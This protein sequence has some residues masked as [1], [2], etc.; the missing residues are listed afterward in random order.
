MNGFTACGAAGSRVPP[1]PAKRVNFRHGLVLG[2][3]ELT[4]ESAYLANRAESLARD[5]FGYGTVSGLR[6][7]REIRPSGAAIV[8][9]AG[10][11]LSPRGRPIRVAM[12]QALALN[13]WLDAHRNRI[14]FKLTPGGGS[15]P[16]DQLNL[17]VVLGYRQCATD[18]QPG[19]GE[20]CRTDEPPQIFTR[21][22]DDFCLE[23]RFDAPDQRERDAVRA[24]VSWIDLVEFVDGA[25]VTAT[26][27]EFLTALRAAAL[28][29][30]PPD[31]ALASPPDALRVHVDDAAAFL[32]A[33]LGVWATELKPLWLAPAPQ[34]DSVLLAEVD[35]PVRSAPNGRWIVDQPSRIALDEERRPY[36]VPLG[37]LQELGLML[38]PSGKVE[39]LRTH[40][41]FSVAAAGII[42]GDPTNKTHRRPLFNG[43][44]VTAVANGVVSIAFDGYQQP[45]P[46]GDFQ[47]LVKATSGLRAASP[48]PVVITIGGFDPKSI[49]LTVTSLDAKALPVAE[50]RNL[51]MTIEIMRYPSERRS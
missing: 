21:I 51:E 34:D 23:L 17:F 29:G 48:I 3:V 50:L 42:T 13:E 28:P 31:I 24:F 36:L 4:Q 19:P 45:S 25:G 38:G 18:N 43:L 37:M 8:V 26:L 49:R 5:L 11:A 14:P 6:V 9:S 2:P 30:S 32:R 22:A 33:A 7:T 44:T 41:P 46:Q 10:T 20:P 16:G 15:P 47:Y 12:P 1:D 39:P 35:V 27:D 40:V